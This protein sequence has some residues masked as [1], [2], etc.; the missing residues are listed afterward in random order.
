MWALTLH[1]ISLPYN[2]M[3]TYMYIEKNYIFFYEK[4]FYATYDDLDSMQIRLTSW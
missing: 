1:S 4:Y 3:Y 2:L